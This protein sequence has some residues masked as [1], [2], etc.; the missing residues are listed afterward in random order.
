MT[1]YIYIV[2]GFFIGLCIYQ[3][4]QPIGIT[5]LDICFF[6]IVSILWFIAVPIALG[7][8]LTHICIRLSKTEWM[9]KSFGGKK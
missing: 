3:Y 2:I 7:I 4:R 9:N 1:N 6:F 5:P 8:G